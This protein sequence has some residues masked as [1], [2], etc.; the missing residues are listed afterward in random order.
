MVEDQLLQEGY[1]L[2]TA[3]MLQIQEVFQPYY[4]DFF[5]ELSECRNLI[6]DCERYVHEVL[7]HLKKLKIR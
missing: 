7:L 4:Q 5:V 2:A 1:D 3:E 6:Y